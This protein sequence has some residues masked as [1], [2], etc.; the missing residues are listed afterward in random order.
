MHE[1]S[2]E[3]IKQREQENPDNIDEVPI[4]AGHFD[5]HVIFRTVGIA[6]SHPSEPSHQ[7]KADDHMQGMEAGHHKID[8]EKD[9]H[10]IAEFVGIDLAV[11]KI[12]DL[13]RSCEYFVI[14][15]KLC[16]RTIR[17]LKFATRIDVFVNFAVC[18]LVQ[19]FSL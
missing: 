19:G 7:P 15:P 11:R 17:P 3:Q 2:P 12:P 14:Q 4:E 8:P 9:P 16:Q 5:R 13:L 1:M 6:E 18:D 10:L